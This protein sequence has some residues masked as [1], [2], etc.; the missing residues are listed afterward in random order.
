MGEGGREGLEQVEEE[1]RGRRIEED[2]DRRYEA[3][4]GHGEIR[5]DGRREDVRGME[6]R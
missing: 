5:G 2:R 6:K 1:D 4:G 3:E